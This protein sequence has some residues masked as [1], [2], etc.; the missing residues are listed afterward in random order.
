MTK[1]VGQSDY[2]FYMTRSWSVQK[3]PYVNDLPFSF[4]KRIRTSWQGVF[5]GSQNFGP[6]K[7][8]SY[9]PHLAN[10]AYEKL[11]GK[12]GDSS[13]WANNLLEANESL[14]MV[15]SVAHSLLKAAIAVRKKDV[16]GVLNAFGI[17]GN[18]S[19]SNKVSR[20]VRGSKSF[21]NKWLELHFG[22]VPMA[23]DIHS[24]VQTLS[25]PE[26]CGSRRQ[27]VSRSDHYRTVVD[28]IVHNSSNFGG[29]MTTE[30]VTYHY[31]LRCRVSISNLNAFKANQM[32]VI[33]PLSVAWEA[34]PYSF[35]VDWF[36][37]VGQ[38]LSAMTDFVGLSITHSSN[39][40]FQQ[41]TLDK[42]AFLIGTD[43]DYNTSTT[44]YSVFCD[45][46]L[47]IPGP[48]LELKPF[49]GLSVVRGATAISLLLQHL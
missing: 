5:P 1:T 21:G 22:W 10:Q 19:K 48:T 31:T 24:A 25:K 12:L 42:L 15:A 4:Q 46:G 7:G 9:S 30:D 34:V 45:R 39:T 23:Q 47:G 37:N 16:R 35:V 18:V 11:V 40:L 13:Q 3:P 17:R 43:H 32:G 26:L 6:D 38:C 49:K 29:S 36:S 8:S 41:G 44:G 2:G 14:D 33:N 28:H 20:I 27:V